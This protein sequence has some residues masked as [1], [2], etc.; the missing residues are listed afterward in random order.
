[1]GAALA[2]TLAL[3]LSAGAVSWL[4]VERPVLRW[5]RPPRRAREHAPPRRREP[6]T[7]GATA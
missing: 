1:L 3:S 4:A 6:A 2:I 7:A 5:T